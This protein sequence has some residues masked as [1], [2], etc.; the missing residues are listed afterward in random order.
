M[1]KPKIFSN[2]ER[3]TKAKE[4]EEE[5]MNRLVDE[6]REIVPKLNIN[7]ENV[8]YLGSSSGLLRMGKDS[9]GVYIVGQ[10]GKYLT[11]QAEQLKRRLDIEFPDENF[12]LE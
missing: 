6:A 7:D 12:R 8:T 1:E 5:V 3:I 2:D 4:R 11:K 9:Y 10:E